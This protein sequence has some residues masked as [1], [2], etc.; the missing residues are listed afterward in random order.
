MYSF[1]IALRSEYFFV[2]STGTDV[3]LRPWGWRARARDTLV[4]PEHPACALADRAAL[5]LPPLPRGSETVPSPHGPLEELRF[6]S[7]SGGEQADVRPD[8]CVRG[9]LVQNDG[10]RS[11][12][13]RSPEVPRGLFVRSA[14]SWY[15]CRKEG[16]GE[17]LRAP[18]G[19]AP[20]AACFAGAEG[21]SGSAS[22]GFSV[23]MAP[24]S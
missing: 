10:R 24:V 1:S 17:P 23:L 15:R 16:V 8:R 18:V 3:L 9:S 13:R 21:T 5:C 6:A 11:Q 4:L 7:L 20:G 12:C 2:N 14:S 22:A 19:W